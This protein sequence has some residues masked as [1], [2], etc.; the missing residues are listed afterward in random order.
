MAPAVF[1]S[2]SFGDSPSGVIGGG[3]IGY[4]LQLGQWVAGL[5]G[6][7]DGTSFSRTVTDPFGGLA[8]QTKDSIQG[9]IRLRAGYAWDRVLVY[10]TGGVAFAGVDDE[11]FD[12]IG[13]ITG[14]PGASEKISK[15][16]TGW[17][18]GGGLE[19][20]LTDN[21][22]VR[23]EYRYSDFGH[24]T[25][26]PFASFLFAPAAP[27]PLLGAGILSVQHHLTENQVQVGLSYKFG[28]RPGAGC[29]EVLI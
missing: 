24:Y 7:V 8:V 18:V 17:T 2:N 25:D 21:W 16:R 27:I 26:T 12:P 3:H 23:A 11:Y 22:S 15:T 5:E 19:Y 10:A 13:T 4:N 29:R 9:S 20:A 28:S 14:V 6:T 1:I